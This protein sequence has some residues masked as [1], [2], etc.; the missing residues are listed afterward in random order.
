MGWFSKKPD[1][2]YKKHVDAVLSLTSSLFERLVKTELALP[3]ACSLPD[4]LF[5]CMMFSLVTVYTNVYGKLKKPDSV[6][7]DCCVS[8]T[9]HCLQSS[10]LLFGGDISQQEATS[11]SGRHCSFF[12][13]NWGNHITSGRF[14]TPAGRAVVATMLSYVISETP[15]DTTQ[16]VTLSTLATKFKQ[17]TDDITSAFGRMVL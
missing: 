12:L 17:I 10:Q 1:V 2:E 14:T 3:S 4:S 9:I 15:P 13:N 11:I 6:L 5:R 8:I 16:T 7:A